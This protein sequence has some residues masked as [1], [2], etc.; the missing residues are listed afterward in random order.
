MR[1]RFAYLETNESYKFTFESGEST[2]QVYP[3]QVTMHATYSILNAYIYSP[4]CKFAN[5]HMTVCSMYV[6][7]YN[8]QM[9]YHQ[10]ELHCQSLIHFKLD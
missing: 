2:A 5:M 3:G 10:T 9:V 6:A 7:L 1:E 4:T 8:L